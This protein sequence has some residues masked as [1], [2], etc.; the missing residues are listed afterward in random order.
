MIDRLLALQERGRLL[1][2]SGRA[3]ASD[4]MQDDSLKKEIDV[5]YQHYFGRAITGCKN[6]YVDALIELCTIKKTTAMSKTDLFVVRRGKVL[7]DT[8]TNDAR[9]NLVRGNET[10]ELALYHLYTNP[11]SHQFFERLPD[12]DR[13]EEMLVEYGKKFESNR[14]AKHG[15]GTGVTAADKV[16][17]DAKEKAAIIGEEAQAKF[18]EAEKA[19]AESKKQIEGAKTEAAEIV[20]E[21]EAQAEE[22]VSDAKITAKTEAA[23][24][25]KEAEAV[26]KKIVADAKTAAKKASAKAD[27]DPMLK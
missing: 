21:A 20:K 10:E 16:I 6:C 3:A 9:L 12:D 23:E 13:L 7:R 18:E 26:A 27:D 25:V 19:E 15:D 22:I 8:L 5:L 1:I 2:N 11:N 17:N 24:T 14:N 4:I